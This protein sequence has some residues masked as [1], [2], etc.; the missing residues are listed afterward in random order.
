MIKDADTSELV[1]RYNYLVEKYVELATELATKLEKFGKYKKE[2][3]VITAEFVDR[4]FDYKDSESLTKL[5]EE[6][7]KKRENN[8]E[9]EIDKD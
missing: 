3:Q 6:E 4:G 2:L 8:G 7:I 5:I 9:Q 1:D